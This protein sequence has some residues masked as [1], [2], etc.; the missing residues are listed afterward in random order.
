M[1]TIKGY[2]FTFDGY[3]DCFIYSIHSTD[4][5]S[6]KSELLKKFPKAVNIECIEY[7]DI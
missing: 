4:F 2:T 6:A 1:N 7:D 3:L 5:I